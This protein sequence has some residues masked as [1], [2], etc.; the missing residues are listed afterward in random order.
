MLVKFLNFVRHLQLSPEKC[1]TMRS[2]R[3]N[4]RTSL[5]AVGAPQPIASTSF[6]RGRIV[7]G[8]MNDD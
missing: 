4:S 2:E 6:R 3:E 5:V 8:G 1:A 7:A